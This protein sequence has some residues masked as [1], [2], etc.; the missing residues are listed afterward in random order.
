KVFSL[1]LH[2]AQDL[3]PASQKLR[4]S[5]SDEHV[6]FEMDGAFF[7][8]HFRL[9]RE[10]HAGAIDLGFHF[11]ERRRFRARHADAVADAFGTVHGLVAAFEQLAV[12]HA[13]HFGDRRAGSH[14]CEADIDDVTGGFMIFSVLFRRLTEDGHARDIAVVTFVAGAEVG[15]HAVALVVA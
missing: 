12:G 15:D 6:L 9:D 10:Y 7:R 2:Y 8:A 1:L 13:R 3:T 4:A 14:R 5:F 11:V